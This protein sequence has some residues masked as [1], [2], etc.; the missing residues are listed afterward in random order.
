MGVDAVLVEGDELDRLARPWDDAV[1]RTPDADEFCASSRWSFAAAAS[2]DHAGPASVITDGI[3][4]AGMRPATAEDGTSLL[5]GLDPVWGFATPLVGHPLRAAAALAAHLRRT[6]VDLALVAGQLDDGPMLHGLAR[7]VGRDHRLLRGEEE[8][9]LRADVGDGFE[10]WWMRRSPGFRQQLRRLERAA[11]DAGVVIAD[12]SALAPDDAMD[13]VL[14]IEARSWKG[15]E[16]TG[17]ASDELAAFYRRVVWRLATAEHLRLLV[18]RV[19]DEDVAFVLG[20]IRGT[21][22]RGLQ[23]SH[24]AAHAHLGLGHLLQLHQ[25]RALAGTGIHT[26]DLG[27]D[28][29]YKRRWADRTDTTFS[30][31][32]AR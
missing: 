14:A 20:G 27:M 1:D 10:A 6:P 2:F 3:G 30:V 25:V 21:T 19:G 16:G 23:L 24:D 11:A 7:V 15:Q 28:M 22:Y 18:A 12:L 5:L 8:H 17:L 9:R 29:E 26:Y 4:F 31:L 13:R 32:V